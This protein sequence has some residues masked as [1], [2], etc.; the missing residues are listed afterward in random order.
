MSD[1]RVRRLLVGGQAA[2][3]ERAGFELA[4]DGRINVGAVA[5]EIHDGR[6]GME[7]EL[8]GVDTTELDGLA[9]RLADA[10]AAEP[11]GHPNGVT[12]IDHVVAFSPD[13]DRTVEVLEEAG[14]SLRRIREEPTPAGAPRQAFF[15]L[16]EVI[17][18]VVQ[19][20][21]SAP[22]F[23]SAGPARLWGLAVN[24][25][26]LEALAARI[27]EAARG[28]RPAVQPG[29]QIVTVSREAGLA[30]PVAF[31]SPRP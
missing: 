29:R 6:R 14:L 5:I 18:E 31:M 12:S 28:P 13:L 25:P 16:G 7:W 11:G 19:Q 10:P 3:W 26:D 22:D 15:R 17:L 8:S 9:T 4:D 27:G 21:S 2:G 30:V 1:A 24:C 20:P 23:D